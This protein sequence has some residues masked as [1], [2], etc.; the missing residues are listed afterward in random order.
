MDG[1]D[2][3]FYRLDLATPPAV[4]PQGGVAFSAASRSMEICPVEGSS[5]SPEDIRLTVQLTDAGGQSSKTAVKPRLFS[6]PKLPVICAS[7]GWRK[8]GAEG[9]I[10]LQPLPCFSRTAFP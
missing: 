4:Q 5:C 1:T 2:E 6:R 10:R 8:D 3:G 9:S 7:P